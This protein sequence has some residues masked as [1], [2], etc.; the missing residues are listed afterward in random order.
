MVKDDD[1]CVTITAF[2]SWK[3]EDEELKI[4]LASIVNLSAAWGYKKA[5]H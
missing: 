5:G 4:I 1:V 2:G 3:N